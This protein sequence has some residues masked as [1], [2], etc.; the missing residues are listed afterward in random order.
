MATTIK[1]IISALDIKEVSGDTGTKI[2][3]VSADS[4]RV[5]K[6]YLF[7]SI[8]GYKEDGSKY[9]NDALSKGAVAV[10]SEDKIELPST[11]TLVLVSD[12]R[13]ALAKI[14]KE[15]YND[16][17]MKMCVIGITGTNGKTTISYLLEAVFV[18]NS[19]NVGVIGTIEYRYANKHVP[20]L[21]TT[22]QSSEL[23]RMM[24]EMADSGVRYVALEVSS[25]ALVQDRVMGCEFD[26]GVFTNLTRDHL[27]FHKTFENYLEAKTKL[28]EMLR[29]TKKKKFPKCAVINADDPRSSHIVERTKV[30][31]M[32]YG[33]DY[34]PADFSVQYLQARDIKLS[35]QGCEFSILLNG[36][37]LGNIKLRLIGKS[38]IYNALAAIGVGLSQKIDIAVI[39]KALGKVGHIPGRFEL[40]EEGQK[41]M[42]VV[43]YAHTDD[44]LYRTLLSVRELSPNRIITVF[45]CGGDRDR[46]KRPLMGEVAVTNSDLSIIT[47]DNPRSEDPAKIALDVE[48]GIKR[49]GKTNYRIILDRAKA[50]EEALSEAQEGDVVLIAGKGHET[51]QIFSDRTIYFSDT[52]VAKQVLQ[53]IAARKSKTSK[54]QELL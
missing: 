49:T 17:S 19:K 30:P 21:T 8:R 43:D 39:K 22:P 33:I 23:Q 41:F 9:I 13:K 4:R 27:D 14:S 40:I 10:V 6:G 15:F 29:E 18:E 1:K 31:V 50:I 52:E 34:T 32:L 25:H 51:T 26:V 54:Q 42:V 48:I 2:T 47:S 20:A 7:V 38:N 35:R 11:V 45:G 37:K 3:G 28:F 16:P 12:S 36:T 53:M 5:E 46:T 24:A 44:A